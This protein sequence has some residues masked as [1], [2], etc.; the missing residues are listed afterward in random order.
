MR[1]DEIG[2][3]GFLYVAGLRLYERHRMSVQR[4]INL[5]IDL[6]DRPEGLI[7][8]GLHFE[9]FEKAVVE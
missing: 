6:V 7:L 1:K 2:S 8:F 4:P 3:R 9:L 5:K